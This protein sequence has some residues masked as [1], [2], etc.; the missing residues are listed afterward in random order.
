MGYR[1]A[2]Y[3]NLLNQIIKFF[4]FFIPPPSVPPSSSCVIIE[5]EEY[6]L[7]LIMRKEIQLASSYVPYYHSLFIV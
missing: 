6:V 4:F 1:G 5:E 7:G 2:A 3:I